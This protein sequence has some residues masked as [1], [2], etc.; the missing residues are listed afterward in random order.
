MALTEAILPPQ[1]AGIKDTVSHEDN[2]TGCMPPFSDEIDAKSASQEVSSHESSI[3]ERLRYE[4]SRR[5]TTLVGGAASDTDN[6]KIDP[7]RE[8]GPLSPTEDERGSLHL[9]PSFLRSLNNTVNEWWLW[10]LFGWLLSLLALTALIAFLAIHDNKAPPR[11]QPGI[12]LNAI[13][14]V[15]AIVAQTAM[16]IP[17]AQ[18]ISQL[19]WQWFHHRQP[20]N[21]MQL[22]DD[23]S[24][25]PWGALRLLFSTRALLVY[26]RSTMFDL[27][28]DRPKRLTISLRNLQSLGA[29]IA[30]LALA[31]EPFI[32][33]VVSYPLQRVRSGDASIN[34]VRYYN[35]TGEE[36]NWGPPT[37]D[38]DLPMKAAIHQ[39]IFAESNQMAFACSTGNCTW[40][41]FSSLAICSHCQNIEVKISTVPGIPT[42]LSTSNGLKIQKNL[43]NGYAVLSESRLAAPDLGYTDNTIS[44][45]T[46]LG[47][48]EPL[49][50]GCALFWCVQEISASVTAGKYHEDVIKTWSN[51]S[52]RNSGC[53]KDNVS[54]C[55][56]NVIGNHILSLVGNLDDITNYTTNFSVGVATQAMF[57]H[58]LGNFFTG[59]VSTSMAQSDLTFSSDFM[60]ALVP[61]RSSSANGIGINLTNV[62]QLMSNISQSMTIRMRQSAGNDPNTQILGDAYRLD[63]FIKVRWVWLALPLTLLLLTLVFLL[64]A[65]RTSAQA[66]VLPWKSSSIALLFHGLSEDRRKAGRWEERRAELHEIAGEMKVQL[67]KTDQGWRLV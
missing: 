40:P 20:L 52:L 3:S 9:A 60:A 62:P 17:I 22:F 66:K 2:Y 6:G 67:V 50:Y 56:M 45:F 15:C 38:I 41:N 35:I 49:A 61:S 33:Q 28:N 31:I 25:G 13:I 5:P 65:I 23:A 16:M 1:E 63:S 59:N 24:R 44:N 64:A 26:Q 30:I 51:A 34:S 43:P 54:V 11:W 18:G 42:V 39:A 7:D 53:D 48:G 58:F 27:V 46:I 37:Y 47:S 57:E 4:H 55:D 10:E 21:T 29:V 36:T 14:S 8:P 12:T 19:K 32:Q